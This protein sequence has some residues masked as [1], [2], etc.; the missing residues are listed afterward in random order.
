MAS[1]LTWWVSTTKGSALAQAS[2]SRPITRGT[3]ERLLA[4]VIDRAE[5]FNADGSHVIDIA[6]LV[7]FG[8]YL[9]PDMQH[10]GDLDLGVTFRNR[11]PDTTATVDRSKILLDYAKASGHRFHDSFGRLSWAEDEALQILR[12]RS[13]AIN[14]TDENVRTLTDRW[15][16][17]YSYHVP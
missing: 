1:W 7:V 8:S 15:E 11:V 17:V 16:V 12:N 10:L 6:E 9:D 2:F 14:L 4:G 5:K 3:A 13:A